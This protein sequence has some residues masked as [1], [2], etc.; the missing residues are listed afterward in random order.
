MDEH[1]NSEPPDDIRHM[2][3]EQTNP[4]TVKYAKM[5]PPDEKEDPTPLTSQWSHSYQSKNMQ[6]TMWSPPPEN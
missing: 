4:E 5:Y 2:R 6:K 3:I 1:P